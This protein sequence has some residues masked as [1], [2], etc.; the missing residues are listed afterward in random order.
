MHS[1]VIVAAIAVSASVSTPA[2]QAPEPDGRWALMG[3]SAVTG[4]GLYGWLLPGA[5]GLRD[6]QAAG[7]YGL[8]AA[9]S[10]IVP[11]ALLKDTPVSW[12]M[13]N[14]FFGAALHGPF[15]GFLLASA[16]GISPGSPAM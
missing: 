12:G 7:A 2:P 16:L 1:L 9:G 8:V 15:H 10:A 3:A 6:A 13:A 4:V 14:L 11:F 5:F